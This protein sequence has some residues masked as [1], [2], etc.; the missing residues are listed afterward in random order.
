MISDS[1]KSKEKSFNSL[2]LYIPLW[3]NYLK[4][5]KGEVAHEL[6]PHPS[7]SRDLYPSV[8]ILNHVSQVELGNI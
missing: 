3:Y 7:H 5:D 8:M 2:F 1:G 6:E 4:Y